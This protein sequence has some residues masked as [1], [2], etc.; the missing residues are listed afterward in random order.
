L[1]NLSQYIYKGEPEPSI[2]E[3]C[4]AEFK[5][6]AQLDGCWC[7]EVQLSEAVKVE[8]RARYKRCLCR[9]CLESFVEPEK[10]AVLRK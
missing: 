5:C 6:G 7:A 9:V 1:R 2:C 8:L 4:G 10:E 3:A